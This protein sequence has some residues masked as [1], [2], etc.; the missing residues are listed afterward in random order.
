MY[1]GGRGNNAGRQVTL[2]GKELE[3]EKGFRKGC[4]KR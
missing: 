3:E 4:E 1:E 2:E